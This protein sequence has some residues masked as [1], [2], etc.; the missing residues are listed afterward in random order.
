MTTKKKPKPPHPDAVVKVSDADA[1]MMFVGDW[2]EKLNLRDWRIQRSAKACGKAN[3]AEIN[4]IVMDARMATYTIGADF[5]S[6]PVTGQSVE[7]VA[8]HEVLHVFLRELIETASES[9][10]VSQETL[11]G[12]EHRVIN[13]LVNLLVPKA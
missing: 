7:E 12:V 10:T 5:G 8:C 11:E 3:M 4:K 9:Q 2:Q 1:F 13:V 6:L